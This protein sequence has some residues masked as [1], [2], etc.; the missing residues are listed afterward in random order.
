MQRGNKGYIRKKGI[1]M[2]TEQLQAGRKTL[3]EITKFTDFKKAFNNPHGNS[4]RASAYSNENSLSRDDKV[5]FINND[6]ELYKLI[7][8]YLD[9]KIKK[10][11]K[12]F[13]KI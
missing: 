2:T 9:E 10:L 6:D 13:E 7:N 12:E 5:I 11:R 3:D 1:K 4:L 8:D